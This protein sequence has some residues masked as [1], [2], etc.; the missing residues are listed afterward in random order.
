MMGCV[1][2]YLL[3]KKKKW[4]IHI[5]YTFFNNKKKNNENI[6]LLSTNILRHLGCV[7][8]LSNVDEKWDFVCSKMYSNKK[9][10][11]LYVI[12]IIR[13]YFFRTNSDGE[14]GSW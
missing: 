14:E 13:K 10:N 11:A 4:F 3:K 8:D 5:K 12:M 9:T 1:I 2:F 6:Y 7:D